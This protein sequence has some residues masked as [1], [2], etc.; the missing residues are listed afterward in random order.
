MVVAEWAAEVL[1][2]R[3]DDRF[4]STVSATKRSCSEK[5]MLNESD[6]NTLTHGKF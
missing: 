6:V 5:M 2:L 4:T 3:N 1:D